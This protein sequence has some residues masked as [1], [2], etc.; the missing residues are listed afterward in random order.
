MTCTLNRFT[1]DTLDA[2]PGYL[3]GFEMPLVNDRK[4]AYPHRQLILQDHIVEVGEV[5]TA[6]D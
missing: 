3:I 5:G 6:Q 2:L 4:F 1:F